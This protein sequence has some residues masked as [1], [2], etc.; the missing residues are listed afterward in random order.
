MGRDPEHNN[1]D[2]EVRA[3]SNDNIETAFSGR[4]GV[5]P[6]MRT[7]RNG[8]PWCSFTVAIG[9]DDATEWISIAVFGDRAEEISGALP[10]GTRV[11]VEGRLS[12]K[13]WADRDGAER[14]GLQVAATLV[15]PLGQ[16][17]R[18]RPA[19]SRSASAADTPDRRDWQR[20][21]SGSSESGLDESIPF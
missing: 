11:Y 4:V 18:R 2:S 7:S 21:A 9:A 10:K 8:K 16:I 20:P 19:G 3:V 12:L 5:E 15:Q 17:G 14:S 6:T 13:R 1:I